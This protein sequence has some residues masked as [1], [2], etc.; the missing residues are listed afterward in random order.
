VGERGQAL[1]GGERQRVAIARAVLIDPKILILDEATSAV[2]AQTEREIQR[3]LD[4]V[5][6]GRTTIAIAHR[7]STLRKANKLIVLNQGRIVETGTHTA[8]LAKGGEYARLYQAQMQSTLG[9]DSVEALTAAELERDTS[10]S[11]QSWH[12]LE[13]TLGEQVLSPLGHG[14]LQLCFG[15]EVRTVHPVRCFPL[16]EPLKWIALVD[17]KGGEFALIESLDGLEQGQR[18]CIETA[19]REREFLPV[20]TGIHGIS[21]E[22]AHSVW[23]ISTD[24][25]ETQFALGHDDH[26]RPLTKERFVVTDTHGMRYLV[27]DIRRLDAKSQRLLSRYF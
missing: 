4:N 21:V 23:Q 16:T 3:A 10:E 5:V 20:I 6:Q 24:R 27:T 11:T 2:D 8:L 19:L 26:V 22:P 12:A 9:R 18:A 1:S 17:D 25:G 15:S 14:N 7:L 13:R